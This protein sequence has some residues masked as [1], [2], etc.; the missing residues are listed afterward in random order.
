MN[1][2]PANVGA[3]I[4]ARTQS[5]QTSIEDLDPVIGRIEG[6]ANRAMD[7]ADK[8]LGSRPS[9]VAKD[10]PIPSPSHLM[11]SIQ[12]RRE[13]LVRAT[14]FLESEIARLADGLGLT[15]GG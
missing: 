9:E 15:R 7:C 14:D 4:Q 11:Y 2:G 10:A 8:L 13:R 12:A 1:Y 5:M 3:P 6:L